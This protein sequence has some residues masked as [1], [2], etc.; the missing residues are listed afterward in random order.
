[1]DRRQRRED[2]VRRERE[3]RQPTR[4]VLQRLDMITARRAARRSDGR[5]GSDGSGER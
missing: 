5:E 1:M 2:I 3:R 4:T